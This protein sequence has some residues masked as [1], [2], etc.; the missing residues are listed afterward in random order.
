M[1]GNEVLPS[2]KH[3]TEILANMAEVS[4]EASLWS[5]KDRQGWVWIWGLKGSLT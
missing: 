2:V 3:W 5:G 1:D 4:K